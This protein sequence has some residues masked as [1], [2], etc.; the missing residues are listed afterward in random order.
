MYH[1]YVNMKLFT[2]YFCEDTV[3]MRGSDHLKFTQEAAYSIPCIALSSMIPFF[4]HFR[5][6]TLLF[7]MHV[8]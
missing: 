4:V 7:S 6:F 5:Y 2:L 8:Q 1:I 3:R